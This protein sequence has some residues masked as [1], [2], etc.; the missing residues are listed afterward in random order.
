MAATAVA[1]TRP[2]L[3]STP[4]RALMLGIAGTGER[5]SVIPDDDDIIGALIT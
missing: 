3:D 5:Q 4:F 1:R 2:G